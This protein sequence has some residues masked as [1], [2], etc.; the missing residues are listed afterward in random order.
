MNDFLEA[1]DC[2]TVLPRHHNDIY[3]LDIVT[4]VQVG[5]DRTTGTLC[6]LAKWLT[7]ELEFF[8]FSVHISYQFLSILPNSLEGCNLIKFMTLFSFYFGFIVLCV[9][10]FLVAGRGVCVFSLFTMNLII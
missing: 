6:D 4:I 1:I 10:N 3:A 9:V 8:L 2:E 5:T 7:I